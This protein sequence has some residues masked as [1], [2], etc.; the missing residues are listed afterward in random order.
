MK[1][2]KVNIIWN[3]SFVCP[4]DCKFCATGAVQVKRNNN[5]IVM[6][7]SDSSSEIEIEN[8][9]LHH[10]EFKR[11]LNEGITPNIFDMALH[12]RQK[13]G[14]ELNYEQKIKVLDNILPT[15]AKI[16]FSGGD[17]LACYENYLVI[18]EAAN[19]FGK[20]NISIT[21]TGASFNRYDPKDI[22]SI[23]GTLDFTFDEPTTSDPINRPAG[24]NNSNLNLAKIF[25]ALSLRTRAQLPI[26]L[27]NLES[28]KIVNIYTALHDAG[29]EELLLMRVFPVG[30][31]NHSSGSN[32]TVSKKEYL[33]AIEQYQELENRLKYP[34]V[35]LQCAL[36]SVSNKNFSQNPC[37]LMQNS[38]GITPKG[39]LLI[40]AWATS[41]EDSPY[42][43]IFVL[44]NLNENSLD[45]LLNTKK[46]HEYQ[47]KLDNNWGHCKMFSFFNTNSKNTSS[48]FE[49]NDPLYILK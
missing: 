10:N 19:R 38:F 22:T 20:E 15:Q 12:Q 48:L 29:V 3:M 49:K 36:K 14:A 7:E 45:T 34:R 30:R 9:N 2:D 21:G 37:D 13:M 43:D 27:G 46:V 40:S 47:S 23:A 41:F 26:H 35:V 32:Y 42:R 24:Y 25:A 16:D 39:N 33:A 4:W 18:K 6:I 11:I 5:S 44:G 31:G 1:L 8:I 28:T 17:P